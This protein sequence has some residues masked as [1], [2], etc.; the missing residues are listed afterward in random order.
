MDYGEKLQSQQITTQSMFKKTSLQ[1]RPCLQRLCLQH[2]Q[3]RDIYTIL[4]YQKFHTTSN[5]LVSKAYPTQMLS[6][7]IPN[8]LPKPVQLAFISRNLLILFL[9]LSN[10]IFIKNRLAALH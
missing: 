2:S 10:S 5:Y 7:R 9:P 1:S 6:K 4:R 8:H 3:N